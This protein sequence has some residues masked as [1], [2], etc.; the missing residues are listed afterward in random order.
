MPPS[1][2]HN[3]LIAA[4]KKADP[5]CT[6]HSKGA[7]SGLYT[8]IHS[9]K[10]AV[11]SKSCRSHQ[12]VIHS[13]GSVVLTNA[14]AGPLALTLR[15]K[16]SVKVHPLG[17]GSGAPGNYGRFKHGETGPDI[18]VRWGTY[19]AFARDV[20]NVLKGRGLW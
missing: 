11:A 19:D 3:A 1:P 15:P 14:L 9:A 6:H 5:Q 18:L 4:F 8:H 7:G 16:V 12:V 20:V 10:Q 13:N 17:G 2:V